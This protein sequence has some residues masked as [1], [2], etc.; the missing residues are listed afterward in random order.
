VPGDADLVIVPGT[1]STRGDLAYLRRQGW[2]IDL[3]AHLRRGGHVLGL[4]GGYQMLGRHLSDPNG[5]D[6]PSGEV[7]GLGLL[8]VTTVMGGD[9]RLRHCVAT[10]LPDG[11]PVTG[12]EIHMGQTDGP[13]CARAWLQIDGRPEGAAS[14][15]GLVRG[16]YLHG[17]FASDGFRARFLA[18]LGHRSSARYEQGVD[19]TLD[20]LAAH[21]ERF[22]DLDALLQLADTPRF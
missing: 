6:G 17:I 13:D 21:L 22:M 5:V 12:Y 19:D 1:K 15:D 7:E 8:N 16:S 3:A 14:E 9:K 18:G 4:C 2:D 10:T 20:A 11:E